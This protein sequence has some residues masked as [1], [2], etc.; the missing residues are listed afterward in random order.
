MSIA[1]PYRTTG[2]LHGACLCKSV[3]ITVDGDYIAAVGGCHCGICQKSNGVFW[4]AFQANAD[5]VQVT[6]DVATYAS[7]PFAERTFC[8]ICGS[9]LWLRDTDDDA[10]VYELMPALFP[11]A[12]KFPLISEIYTDCAPAYATL[13][14]DHRRA[15]KA[16]YESKNP[17]IEGDI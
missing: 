2:V 10:A 11:D 4:A 15:T 8:P 17:H 13:S 9:N 16:E 14:G 3:S 5:A 1:D 12:A 6:G 7:T